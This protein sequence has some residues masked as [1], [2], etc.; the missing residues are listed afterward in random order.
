MSDEAARSE[1]VDHVLDGN[2][3]AGALE[4]AFGADMTAVPGRCGHCGAVAMV[5]EMRAYVRAPGSVLRCP[6]CGGVILRIV[7]TANATYVD[8][9]GAAYLRFDR[10]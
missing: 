2:A 3:V 6:S 7:E 8:A 1:D 5:A 4:A 10:R 9:R